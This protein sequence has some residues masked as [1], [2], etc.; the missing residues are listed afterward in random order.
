[1]VIADQN[2]LTDLRLGP[3]DDAQVERSQKEFTA[4]RERSADEL[5]QVQRPSLTLTPVIV[6]AVVV[7]PSPN[8]APAP[9]ATATPAPSPLRVAAT[10]TGNTTR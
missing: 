9:A 4:L 1:M 6:V 2:L 8:A 10:A 5:P 3:R 7:T